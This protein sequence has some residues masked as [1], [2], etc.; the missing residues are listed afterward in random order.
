MSVL[1]WLFLFHDFR[2]GRVSGDLSGHTE[3]ANGLHLRGDGLQQKRLSGSFG[4]VVGFEG[5]DLG[6]YRP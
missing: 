2:T 3:A 5:P 1:I 4:R 6:H